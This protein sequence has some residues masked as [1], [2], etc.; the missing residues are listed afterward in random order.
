MVSACWPYR[1]IYNNINS[2]IERVVI[3]YVIELYRS[4]Q[5]IFDDCIPFTNLLALLTVSESLRCKPA[6]WKKLA[7]T[8][9]CTWRFRHG[10]VLCIMRPSSSMNG[11]KIKSMIIALE[12]LK[13]SALGNMVF[14]R[15]SSTAASPTSHGV[16][17]TTRNA[18]PA[19]LALPPPPAETLPCP[20][21][22]NVPITEK[23]GLRAPIL[24]ASSMMESARALSRQCLSIPSRI[25]S[26][27]VSL[28][29]KIFA[30]WMRTVML[31]LLQFL[32]GFHFREPPVQPGM[33]RVRWKCVCI[34]VLQYTTKD[35]LN[36]YEIL[37]LWY[38]AVR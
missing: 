12:D 33:K 11:S 25:S 22:R 19:Y 23:S 27:L 21:L 13:E 6:I 37:G 7:M 5:Q 17:R 10:T 26:L 14:R 9:Q 1:S 31:L 38:P 8:Y 2:L 18:L 16:R 24:R 4:L 32:E 20:M 15:L 30:G 36:S 34:P 29:T 35:F 3:S 28:S